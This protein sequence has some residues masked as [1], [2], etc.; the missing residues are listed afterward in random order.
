[1][2]LGN[3]PNKMIGMVPDVDDAL[4]H[5]DEQVEAW[6]HNDDEEEVGNDSTD[7]EE[8]SEEAVEDDESVDQDDGRLER[9]GIRGCKC[10]DQAF[11]SAHG[12]ISFAWAD[13]CHGIDFFEAKVV[14]KKQ[15]DP[16][17]V[18]YIRNVNGVIED[19]LS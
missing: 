13:L 10:I 3:N 4:N 17:N 6:T 12:H 5:A 1:M 9:F 14:R 15:G 7:D 2:A 16:I 19:D 11:S 18:L 8:M